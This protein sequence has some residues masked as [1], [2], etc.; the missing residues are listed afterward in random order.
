MTFQGIWVHVRSLEETRNTGESPVGNDLRVGEGG[1]TSLSKRVDE[2][3]TQ[4]YKP[5]SPTR[6][7]SRPKRLMLK[8][9][10]GITGSSHMN[11]C[12]QSA[13]RLSQTDIDSDKAKGRTGQ[14][15]ARAHSRAAHG[16]FRGRLQVVWI[17]RMSVF[18]VRRS[19]SF[20]SIE[21]LPMFIARS[22]YFQVLRLRYGLSISMFTVDRDVGTFLKRSSLGT[23]HILNSW[24][25]VRI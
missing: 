8:T 15:I 23:H 16:Q 10:C 21:V 4:R 12:I 5:S 13:P 24:M 25:T 18:V 9:G 14:I 7:A 3:Q 17:D 11:A 6:H 20:T 22:R 2:V 1:K 19:F